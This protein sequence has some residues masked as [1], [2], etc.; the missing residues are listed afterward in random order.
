MFSVVPFGSPVNVESGSCECPSEINLDNVSVDVGHVVASG[1]KPVSTLS[2]RKV[3]W[4]KR[5]G[6]VVVPTNFGPTSLGRPSL[7]V[8]CD[9]TQVGDVERCVAGDSANVVVDE[10]LKA[11]RF[12][13]FLAPCKAGRGVRLRAETPC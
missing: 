12:G 10:T 13:G 7:G 2:W 1:N 9:N 4:L 5:R 11:G 6:F 8:G 3:R